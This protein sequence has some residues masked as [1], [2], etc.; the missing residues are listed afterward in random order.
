MSTRAAPPGVFTAKVPH[1]VKRA[2][3]EDSSFGPIATSPLLLPFIFT[4][5]RGSLSGQDTGSNSLVGNAL[6]TRTGWGALTWII[7]FTLLLRFMPRLWPVERVLVYIVLI[8]F[9]LISLVD[10]GKFMFPNALEW[11]VSMMTYVG[12]ENEA[13]RLKSAGAAWI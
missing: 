12:L 4:A 2:Q 6:T 8:F 3:P 13:R 1:W 9:R 7:L 5:A 11:P 10:G